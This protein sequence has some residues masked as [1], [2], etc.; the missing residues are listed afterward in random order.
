MRGNA[1][2]VTAIIAIILVVVLLIPIVMMGRDFQ[3]KTEVTKQA[4]QAERAAAQKAAA[5]EGEN[6]ALKALIGV[7]EATALDELRKEHA[8]IMGRA[9]PGENDST[10]T[11]HDA[12]T[13]LLDDL[14]KEKKAHGTLGNQYA[15]RQSDLNNEKNRFDS[16]VTRITQEKDSVETERRQ[17]ESQFLASRRVQEQNLKEAQNQQNLTLNNSERTRYEL[18]NRVQQLTN[19]NRDMRERHSTLAEMLEDIRNPNVEH[20]AGKI[21][22]V[23]QHAGTAIINLGRADGLGVRTMFNVYHSSI[24]GLT[25]RSAPVGQ[26]SVYCDVCRREMSRDVAKASVE[27][28]HIL[29]EHR[30]EVRILDDILSDPIMAGDVVYSPIWKP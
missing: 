26:D 6:R 8:R 20:P 14:E 25:F 9:L 11:Y 24:T 7:P 15:Q 22:S 16:A 28:M 27:V 5:L 18:N 2:Q 10:R 4:Q 17:Q 23:D 19:D 12:F 13:A 21:I 29:G 30:A 1:W 3:N